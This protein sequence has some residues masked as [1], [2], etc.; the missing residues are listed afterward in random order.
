MVSS[1]TETVRAE[2]TAARGATRPAPISAG[3]GRGESATPKVVQ[4][5]RCP[6]DAR[7]YRAH[8]SHALRPPMLARPGVVNRDELAGVF[9]DGRTRHRDGV[10]AFGGLDLRTSRLSTRR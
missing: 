10:V 8:P 7:S 2:V 3:G 6:D 5:F 9:R 4:N 1:M